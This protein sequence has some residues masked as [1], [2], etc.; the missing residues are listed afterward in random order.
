MC[1]NAIQFNQLKSTLNY[2]Y[3]DHMHVWIKF[4]F[5][6]QWL[7]YIFKMSSNCWRLSGGREFLPISMFSRKKFAVI[8]KL[9]KICQNKIIWA[10]LMILFSFTRWRWPI[11]NLHVWTWIVIDQLFQKYFCFYL[12][13][14]KFIFSVRNCCPKV[15]FLKVCDFMKIYIVPSL[16]KLTCHSS[17]ANNTSLE[18]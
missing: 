11:K 10:N 2:F 3:C 15:C 18:P 12:F 14:R 8:T 6:N 7:K 5:C 1:R 4:E 9:N 16:Y 13:W 17:C